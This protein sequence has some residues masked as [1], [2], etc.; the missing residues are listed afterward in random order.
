MKR[1]RT[2]QERKES[3]ELLSKAHTHMVEDYM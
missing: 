2:E 1:K 3:F